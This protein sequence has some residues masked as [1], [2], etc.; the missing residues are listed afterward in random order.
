MTFKY[1]MVYHKVRYRYNNMIY[2][3]RVELV[4]TEMIVETEQVFLCFTPLGTGSSTLLT[5]NN[6]DS[7]ILTTD[8]SFPTSHSL[9]CQCG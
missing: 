9:C 6:Y 5:A 8:T 1:Y 3:W 2:E 7:A 4:I